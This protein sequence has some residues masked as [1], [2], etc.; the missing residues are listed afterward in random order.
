[1]RY[2]FLVLAFLSGVVFAAPNVVASGSSTFSG[3]SGSV[4]IPAGAAGELIVVV[5]SAVDVDADTAFSTAD[6]GWVTVDSGRSRKV[7]LGVFSKVSDGT[8]TSLA[9]DIG[10]SVDAS[11]V[12]V[13]VDGASV[14]S[15]KH[16]A[17]EGVS[18]NPP[19]KTKANPSDVLVLAVV[20]SHN[21]AVSLPANYGY[22]L[23]ESNG[24]ELAVS[25][26]SLY[27]YGDDPSAYSLSASSKWRCVT[28]LVF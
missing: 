15:A 24:G 14:A 3:S 22:P 10:E 13:R 7:A 1:M 11:A 21:P 2:L 4:A 9:V 27:G 26:R 6:S 12:V 20:A 18:A 16:S 5:V 8:E 17:S 19:S 23:Y 28:V 25:F